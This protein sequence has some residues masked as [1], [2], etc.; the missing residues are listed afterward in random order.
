MY[1]DLMS[2][3]GLPI[4]QGGMQKIIHRVTQAIKSHYDD[5]AKVARSALVRRLG[6]EREHSW[7][8]LQESGVK[9]KNNLTECDVALRGALAQE[10]SR[11]GR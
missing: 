9:P 4:S 3:F 6:H 10:K 7:L 5:I 8:F 1:D 2:V 11:Y